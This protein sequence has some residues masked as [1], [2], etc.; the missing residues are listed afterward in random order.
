[1]IRID[2]IIIVVFWCSHGGHAVGDVA[3]HLCTV[4]ACVNCPMI[5]CSIVLR[6]DILGSLFGYESINVCACLQV[7]QW[8]GSAVMSNPQCCIFSG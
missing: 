4:C 7:L 3:W 8:T 6:V 2:I 1:M 5:L